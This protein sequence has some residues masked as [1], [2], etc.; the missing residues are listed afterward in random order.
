MLTMR[1]LSRIH[2]YQALLVVLYFPLLAVHAEEIAYLDPALGLETNVSHTLAISSSNPFE[3]YFDNLSFNL[4]NRQLSA[5]F[6]TSESTYRSLTS[7]QTFSLSNW[8]NEYIPILNGAPLD[9]VGK[10]LATAISEDEKQVVLISDKESVLYTISRQRIWTHPETDSAISVV[11]SPDKQFVI[12]RFSNGSIR[13]QNFSDGKILFSAFIKKA[14]KQW[15]IWSPEGLFDNSDPDFIPLLYQIKPGKN[16]PLSNLKLKLF[17]PVKVQQIFTSVD[18]ITEEPPQ[19]TFPEIEFKSRLFDQANLCIRSSEKHNMKAYISIN[20]VTVKTF[21]LSPEKYNSGSTCQFEILYKLGPFHTINKVSAKVR[22]MQRLVESK[23]PPQTLD[24][25]SIDPPNM[26]NR[27]FIVNTNDSTK[28]FIKRITPHFKDET[29]VNLSPDS[30]EVLNKEIRPSKLISYTFMLTSYCQLSDNDI[31]FKQS[32]SSKAF[33]SLNK[34]KDKLQ[35][36]NILKSLLL[37]EC[38]NLKKKTDVL[39]IKKIIFP[40]FSDTGR[41]ALFF[42]PSKRQIKQPSDKTSVMQ[43]LLLAAKDGDADLNDDLSV[44]NEELLKYL[45]QNIQLLTFESSGE[46]AIVFTYYNPL[47]R[48]NLPLIMND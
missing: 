10:S 26:S 39:K 27:F 44:T 37:V 25:A 9:L 20:D 35:N 30:L 8:N 15:I 40:F 42:F 6:S 11:I 7:A 47:T 16:I 48:Y 41:S 4:L 18:K 3:V 22:D 13:W 43:K 23:T 45:E 28:K 17:D 29:V 2:L 46:N 32:P 34:L 33:L 38:I 24:F 5:S 19:E 21:K 31:L 14:T 1:L 36:Q 12:T